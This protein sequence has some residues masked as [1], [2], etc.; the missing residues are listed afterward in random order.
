MDDPNRPPFRS[1]KAPQKLPPVRRR[2]DGLS[3]EQRR[4]RPAAA[5]AVIK[6]FGAARAGNSIKGTPTDGHI[7]QNCAPEEKGLEGAKFT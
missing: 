7:E 3:F 5:A 2:F 1:H 4:H 6:R